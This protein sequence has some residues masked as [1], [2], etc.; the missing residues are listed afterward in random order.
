MKATFLACILAGLVVV[1]T[2]RRAREWDS[3]AWLTFLLKL[4]GALTLVAAG[5]R[6]ASAVD[7]GVT[8]GWSSAA[9]AAWATG[10]V[11]GT[12]YGVV[13]GV[14]L[15]LAFAG[16]GRDDRP[17]LWGY[18]KAFTAVMLLGGIGL[19]LQGA[20]GIPFARTGAVV[21]GGFSVWLGAGRPPWF[22]RHAA[23]RL[24]QSQIGEMGTQLLYLGLGLALIGVGLAGGTGCFTP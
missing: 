8:R 19:W 3:G 11:L 4:L 13:L 21:V 22:Q 12:L 14:E 23:V 7:E 2:V 15:L 9:R 1:G 6:M 17:F 18:L 5:S 20:Y 24:I 16:V 10:L